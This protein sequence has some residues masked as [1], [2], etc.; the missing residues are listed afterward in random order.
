MISPLS[1]SN[2]VMVLI[3]LVCAR[4]V[5]NQTAG[6]VR[7]VVVVAIPAALALVVALLLLMEEFYATLVTDGLWLGALLLGFLVGRSRGWM[8]AVQF[9]PE[10][11]SLS[12]PQ[13]WDNLA[14]AFILL[15]LALLD[16]ASATWEEAIFPPAYV[17]AV[18]ALCAGHLAGR[19]FVTLVRA[20]ASPA[21]RRG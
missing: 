19:S 15:G 16:L 4:M 7:S 2:I 11:R 8:L 17:A 10:K 13:T 9:F 18:A 21:P 20:E 3:A 12:A 14:A 5:S 6:R 1:L